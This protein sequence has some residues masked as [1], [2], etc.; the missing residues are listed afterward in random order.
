MCVCV[1]WYL[2]FCVFD[3]LSELSECLYRVRCEFTSVCVCVCVYIYFFSIHSY[4]SDTCVYVCV[5]VL[6]CPGQV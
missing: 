5:H 1:D 2:H 3:G 4:Y 6:V